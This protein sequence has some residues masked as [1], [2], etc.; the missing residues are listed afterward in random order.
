MLTSLL[1]LFCACLILF[2]RVCDN[3]TIQPWKG[4]I[5]SY[6]QDLIKKMKKAESQRM[7]AAK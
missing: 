7:S 4:D 1:S 3:R 6:K 5:R 2:F